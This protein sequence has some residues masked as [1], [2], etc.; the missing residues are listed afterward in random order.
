MTVCIEIVVQYYRCRCTALS[1][2]KGRET[3]QIHSDSICNAEIKVQ[4]V[5]MKMY[6]YRI[7][8]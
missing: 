1:R 2:P 4:M 8:Y 6:I 7:F 3:F 5:F